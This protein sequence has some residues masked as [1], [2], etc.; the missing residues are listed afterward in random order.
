M[1]RGC[2]EHIGA[3][4]RTQTSA[5]MAQA[6]CTALNFPYIELAGCRS[7]RH[8]VATRLFFISGGITNTSPS[9]LLNGTGSGCQRRAAPRCR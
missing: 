3:P 2:L 6:L 8:W 1:S 5:A 7:S 9:L 4:G